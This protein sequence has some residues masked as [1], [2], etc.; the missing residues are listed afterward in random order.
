MELTS[1]NLKT[2][3]FCSHVNDYNRSK[4]FNGQAYLHS[5]I[6]PNSKIN[7]GYLV[8]NE[9]NLTTAL[10]R[11]NSTRILSGQ[12]KCYWNETK[13]FLHLKVLDSSYLLPYEL[14]DIYEEINFSKEILSFSN[15]WDGEESLAI[16][17]DIY[18]KTI[19]FLVEYSVFIFNNLGT[20]I[21]SP[22]INP[23]RNGDMFLSW[24]TEKARLAVNIEKNKEGTYLASYYGDLK[25]NKEPI[26]GNVIIGKVS[27]YLAYWMKNLI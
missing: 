26:K 8:D 12:T 9:I 6:E 3:D 23:G 14:K 2:K 20:I 5:W 19:N 16:S 7:S 10:S 22:E 17:Q 15:N 18:F 1:A 21:N 25:L 11:K 4:I 13:K 24:R 27:D